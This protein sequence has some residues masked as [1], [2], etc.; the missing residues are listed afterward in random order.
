MTSFESLLEKLLVGSDL[1]SREMSD[2]VRSIMS[3]GLSDAQTAAFLVALSGKG[4]TAAEIAA[5][6]QV[7]RDHAV[8]VETGCDDLVDTCGTGGDGRGTFNVSTASAIV[9]ACMGVRIAKHGNRSV[10]SNS[11]SAD[12]LELAGVKLELDAAQVVRCIREV[13]IGFLFAPVFHGAMK[14][15]APARKAIGIRS[16]FNLLGPL[17]NPARATRQVVGVFDA[18]WLRPMAE[19][20]QALGVE[21]VMAVHAEDGLDEISVGAGTRVVE[22][23]DGA[24]REYQVAPADFGCELAP[25]DRIVA[26]GVDDSLAIVERVFAGEAGAA[27]DIVA[28]NAAAAAYI[29][30]RVE[31][32]HEGV[33]AARG[34]M[35]SGAAACKLKEWAD[36]TRRLP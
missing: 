14:Y 35:Q 32:L 19:A 13:G 22:L 36:F 31:N 28:V 30:D 26:T 27:S 6:A 20:A 3:G 9:A 23:R 2:A 8:A 12:F 10:S 24:L 15:A 1:S 25:L 34:V 17:T 11:G 5:A 29:A 33:I 4:E 18:K 7:M 16:V 21:Q